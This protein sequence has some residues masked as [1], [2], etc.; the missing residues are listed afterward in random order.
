MAT[1]TTK[2]RGGEATTNSQFT[3]QQYLFDWWLWSSWWPIKLMIT[4]DNQFWLMLM[5]ISFF[6][7]RYGLQWV[8]LTPW[9]VGLYHK[10]RFG[11]IPEEQ[12]KLP[13]MRNSYTNIPFT[14]DD[15][16]VPHSSESPSMTAFIRSELRGLWPNKKPWLLTMITIAIIFHP[17]SWRLTQRSPRLLYNHVYIHPLK[18]SS[19]RWRGK[20]KILATARLLLGAHRFILPGRLA[21]GDF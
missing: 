5:C 9:H 10:L 12:K 17:R 18:W 4:N 14:Q 20:L 3:K 1:K 8:I 16:Y 15:I 21:V 13:G 6:T 19:K 2:R 11:L 7:P